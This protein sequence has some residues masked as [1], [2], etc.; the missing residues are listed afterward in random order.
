M[1]I[2]E[3]LAWLEVLSK[4]NTSVVSLSG[5]FLKTYRQLIQGDYLWLASPHIPNPV[6]QSKDAAN[7]AKK[8]QLINC[9][10]L[11]DEAW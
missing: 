7:H 3:V 8:K 2:N 6:V 10:N 4:Y 5:S 11:L 1:K 9:L